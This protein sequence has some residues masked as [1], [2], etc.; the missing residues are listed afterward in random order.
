MV[1]FLIKCKNCDQREAVIEELCKGLVG[2]PGYVSDEI[3]VASIPHTC[4]VLMIVGFN[5]SQRT[6]FTVDSDTMDVN[7]RF[8][9]D[10]DT[11]DINYPKR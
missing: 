4:D 10:L 9:V 2:S 3:F 5:D 8:T 7:T 1:K 11:K 6:S